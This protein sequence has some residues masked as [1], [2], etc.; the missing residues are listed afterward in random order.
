MSYAKIINN[1]LDQY[2]YTLADFKA[3][4]PNVSY[5]RNMSQ[6]VLEG[7]GLFLVT[8]GDKPSYDERTQFVSLSATPQEVNSEWK[9]VW[10]VEQKTAAEIQDY[11]TN[12]EVNTRNER[13][14]RLSATDWW[15]A[16]DL[17]MTTEQTAYRQALRDITL[18]ANFPYL[19]ASD[20]PETV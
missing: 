11:D 13:N 4:T 10:S 18:H 2:P 15:G 3:E 12:V 9:L 7:Y 19:Q 1:L 8:E 17:T 5:P 16:S 6:A 20:W 14:A